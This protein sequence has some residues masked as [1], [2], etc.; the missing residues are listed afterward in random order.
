MKVTQLQVGQLQTNCYILEDLQTH[1]ALI[2]DPGDDASL[3]TE[4]IQSEK[5][6][7]KAMIVT[8]GHFDHI[9]AAFELQLNFNLPFY[10]HSKDKFLLDR[11]QQT[12]SHFLGES[13]V[14]IPPKEISLIDS[15]KKINYISSKFKIIHIPGHTPGSIALYSPS[16]GI[17]FSGDLIFSQGGF[18]RTD[19][20]YSSLNNLKDSIKKIFSLPTFTTIYTGHGTATTVEEE[21]KLNPYS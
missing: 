16:D 7:P 15:S 10:L 1:E 14:T 11:I 6:I 20:S 4:I 21:K 17:V 5:L 8:H 19:F 2:I 13:V 9:M 3:I 18:G 12:A